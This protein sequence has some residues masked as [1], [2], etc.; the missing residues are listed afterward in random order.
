MIQYLFIYP[1]SL[2]QLDRVGRYLY[3]G[4]NF[5]QLNVCLADWLCHSGSLCGYLGRCFEH[6]HFMTILDQGNRSSQPCD[7]STDD[8]HVVII[9][10]HAEQ[11]LII[12]LAWP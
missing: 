6:R 10:L 4:T 12:C 5:L 3:A 7:T 2:Q 1:E 11:V 8:Q 9:G